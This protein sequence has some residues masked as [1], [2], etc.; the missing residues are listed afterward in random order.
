MNIDARILNK[1][2]AGTTVCKKD[3]THITKYT[4]YAKVV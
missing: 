2:L 4:G 3:N 1:I